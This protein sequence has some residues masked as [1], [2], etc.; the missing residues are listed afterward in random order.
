M[1]D[2]L[3]PREL[4]NLENFIINLNPPSFRGFFQEYAVQP[5]VSA[6]LKTKCTNGFNNRN[7][8]DFMYRLLFHNKSCILTKKIGNAEYFTSKIYVYQLF[9]Q[10]ICEITKK[11]NLGPLGIDCKLCKN[12]IDAAILHFYIFLDNLKDDQKMEL[13]TSLQK[14]RGFDLENL[15]NHVKSYLMQ[16]HSKEEEEMTEMLEKIANSEPQVYTLEGQEVVEREVVER[17]VVQGEVSYIPEPEQ[18]KQEQ[19]KQ[20]VIK[21][22]QVVQFITLISLISVGVFASGMAG[23]RSKK[24]RRSKK[25]KRSKKQR[26]S[27][28]TKKIM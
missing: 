16:V 8:M 4:L 20:E 27:K 14:I 15:K 11:I 5:L 28:K 1:S 7:N 24:Q 6:I 25:Q 9:C 10:D 12:Y 17:E 19:I 13:N 26:R 2:D 3:T 23:G 22:N 18:I 21:L